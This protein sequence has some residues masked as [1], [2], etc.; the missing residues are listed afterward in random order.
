M[1]FPCNGC[2]EGL[3]PSC[4]DAGRCLGKEGQDGGPA[5]DA[6]LRADSEHLRELN[7]QRRLR[8][9]RYIMA[10]RIELARQGAASDKCI[11]HWPIR[12][13]AMVAV[14]GVAGLLI[15]VARNMISVQP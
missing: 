1:S 3:F 15:A 14:S 13:A 8:R 4:L 5:H 7:R 11:T 10:A 9:Q 12:I 2:S 6:D